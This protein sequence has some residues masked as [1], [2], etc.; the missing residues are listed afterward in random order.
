[1]DV[2]ITGNIKVNF[3]EIIDECDCDMSLMTET[4]A[5]DVADR[6]GVHLAEIGRYMGIS[7]ERARQIERNALTK[8]AENIGVCARDIID[9]G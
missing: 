3:P 7:R 2:L 4:C 9:V 8:L 6:G 5:L 1:M